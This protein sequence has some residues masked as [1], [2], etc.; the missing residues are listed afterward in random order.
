MVS[1]DPSGEVRARAEDPRMDVAIVRASEEVRHAVGRAVS[2]S[3]P[4]ADVLRGKGTGRHDDGVLE[5]VLDDNRS[6]NS[7]VSHC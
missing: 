2:E 4:A 3:R 6:R 7:E 5:I 1:L